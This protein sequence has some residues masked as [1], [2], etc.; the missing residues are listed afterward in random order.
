V[1]EFHKRSL[2]KAISW[3]V[4]ATLTTMAVVYLFTRRLT[5]AVEIGAVEVVAKLLF[6]Y[7]HERIWNWIS[8]G[9]LRHPLDQL[10]VSRELEPEHLDEIKTRLEELGYL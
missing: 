5:L 2:V 8:W 3:R 9:K 4:V 1:R 7:G 6:Y 10:A